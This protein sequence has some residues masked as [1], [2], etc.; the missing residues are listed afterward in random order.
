MKTERPV[1]LS[2]TQ[3]RFPVTAISSVL[4]R[5]AGVLMFLGLPLLLY[6]LH[7][8]LQSQEAFTALQQCISSWWVKLWLWVT[9]SAVLY[10]LLAGIRHIVMDFG[11]GESLMVARCTSWLV[12]LLGVVCAVLTGVWLW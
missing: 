8:S 1:Y 2:L 12:I 10:H 6:L 5:I 11:V 7:H 9:V 3:Y 4:H